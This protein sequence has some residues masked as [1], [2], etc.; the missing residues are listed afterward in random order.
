MRCS[1]GKQL[2]P[3]FSEMS[4]VSK[5]C[6]PRDGH[7]LLLD[8]I[9]IPECPQNLFFVF[10]WTPMLSF[11]P[12]KKI[13]HL[14][15]QF[16]MLQVY[17]GYGVLRSW[18]VLLSQSISFLHLEPLGPAL[19]LQLSWGCPWISWLI[20]YPKKKNCFLNQTP[21]YSH[22]VNHYH[23][24]N[25]NLHNESIQAKIKKLKQMLTSLGKHVTS[26]KTYNK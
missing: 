17:P 22:V 8:T 11:Q 26:C 20:V 9:C 15:L 4:E 19:H 6:V 18:S 23:K 10:R 24:K 3:N 12:A 7:H 25:N 21:R 13:Q 2:K 5:A 16:L 14:Y 1:Q